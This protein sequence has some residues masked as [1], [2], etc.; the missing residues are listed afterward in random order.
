MTILRNFV[1]A[2]ALLVLG[3]V[4]A[5][6]ASRF[7]VGGT[8][9]WDGSTTTHWA[10]TTGGA[11][12][13]TVP[14]A[15]DTVTFD[16]ASGGGTVTVNTNFSIATLVAGAFTGTLDFSA[17]N[18]SPTI[19][20]NV[21]FGGTG[22]RTINMGSG[23]W[24]FTSVSQGNMFSIGNASG[25]TLSAAS[26]TILLSAVATGTRTLN[27]NGQTIGN[28]TV[29]NAAANSFLIDLSLGATIA[30]NLT[31]TNVQGVSI[32][33]G[34]TL[35]VSGTMTYD[36]TQAKPGILRSSSTAAT[37]SVAGATTLSWLTVQNITKA[38]AGS[39]TVNSGVDAGGNTGVTINAPASGRIIGG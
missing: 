22:T 18:N 2:F 17:N 36:G 8:G 32:N 5:D 38:G 12:G 7:W 23:T 37:L 29:T 9:T 20:A 39:I 24:T 3:L 34:S 14:A 16:G 31:L 6:A 27:F 15:G 25:L 11:G 26:S 13:Q 19:S 28:L 21:D 10:A 35:T 1:L 33:G 4:P 30:G